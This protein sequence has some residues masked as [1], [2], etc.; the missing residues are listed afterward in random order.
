MPT[1]SKIDQQQQEA[2]VATILKSLLE[3][4][5]LREVIKSAVDD[6]IESSV[7]RISRNMDILEGRIHDL[8]CKLETSE[9][10]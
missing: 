5:T 2:M 8:E 4:Q 3:S 9:T 6:A 10:E 1:R 7:D